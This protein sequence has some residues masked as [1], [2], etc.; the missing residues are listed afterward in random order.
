MNLRF[1]AA[2]GEQRA[3]EESVLSLFTEFETASSS[4]DSGP[5]EPFDVSMDGGAGETSML[6][7]GAEP[8]MSCTA[9]LSTTSVGGD[10]GGGEP[11]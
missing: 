3:R 11:S 1:K 4:L 5:S 2:W 8:T 9:E 7:G 10:S 6:D